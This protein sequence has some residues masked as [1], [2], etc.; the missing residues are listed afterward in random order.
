MIQVHENS[1]FSSRRETSGRNSTAVAPLLSSSDKFTRV[2]RF[3]WQAITLWEK[4]KQLPRD[5]QTKER[6]IKKLRKKALEKN[7]DEFYFHMINSQV[8][9]DGEHHEKSEEEVVTTDQIRLMQSQDLRYV[10]MKQSMEARKIEKMKSSLHLL[11]VADKPP[12][13]H[14]FFV[15]TQREVDELDLAARLDTAPQL[16]DRNYNRPR[17]ETLRNKRL[18][19]ASDD[20]EATR[21]EMKRSYEML[22]RRIE[23]EKQLFTIAQKLEV[24]RHLANKKEAAPKR[25]HKE[26]KS[27]APANENV[28]L[29]MRRN[30]VLVRI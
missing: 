10:S 28:F 12:V 6:V 2:K 23:R 29:W 20:I 27:L 15:D 21:H 7:P 30:E 24:K 8:D 17:N 13:H 3:H 22:A 1:G 18:R 5:H 11:S 4:K 26:T 16:L 19:V 14:T 9:E 25:V